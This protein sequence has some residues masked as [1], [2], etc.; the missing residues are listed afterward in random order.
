MAEYKNPF[1]ARSM[2]WALMEEDFSD[3]TL[4]Q[5]A[6]VFST[7]HYSISETIRRIYRMT[8]YKVPY[9]NTRRGGGVC[10][11]MRARG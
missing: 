10:G 6:E 4:E 7:N 1:K 8:G 5:I 3:L 2:S 11:R 9:I